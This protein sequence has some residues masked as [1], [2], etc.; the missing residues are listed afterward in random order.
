[1]KEAFEKALEKKTQWIKDLENNFASNEKDYEDASNAHL[2]QIDKMMG[3][4]GTGFSIYLEL[5]IMVEKIPFV[6]Q[7][8]LS[9]S[10]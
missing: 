8:K 3:K 5:G 9:W 6:F 10:L 7:N 2:Y 4:N 1:M